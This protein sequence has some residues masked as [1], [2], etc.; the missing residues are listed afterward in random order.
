MTHRTVT[1]ICQDS[2]T[3][4]MGRV[5]ARQKTLDSLAKRNKEFV[6]V[7]VEAETPRTSLL[8][9]ARERSGASTV[10]NETKLI[11]NSGGESI[12]ISIIS[13]SDG[14]IVFIGLKADNRTIQPI[15]TDFLRAVCSYYEREMASR[16][17]HP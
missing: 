8:Q 16:S 14:K 11:G 2:Q 4:A 7:L 13:T 10:R 15:P 3:G 17:S 9:M 5:D 12:R 6:A 1:R